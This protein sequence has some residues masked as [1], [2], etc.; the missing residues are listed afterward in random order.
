MDA[1]LRV[2]GP[3]TA[4]SAWIAEF[5]E[6]CQQHNLPADFVSTHYYPTDAFGEIGADTETQLANAPRDVMRD[7]AAE[8]RRLAGGRPFTTRSGT[9]H[10]I[11]EIRFTISRSR[12]PM[13]PAF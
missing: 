2:G 12:L 1:S 6:F 5:L 7:R 13:S 11:L 4:Q 3:A 9:C 8:A 10:R